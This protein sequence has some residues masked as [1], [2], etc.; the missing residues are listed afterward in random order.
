MDYKSHVPAGVLL[1]GVAAL[2]AGA[3]AVVEARG[4]GT[5]LLRFDAPV[6]APAPGQS[7]VFYDAARCVI[8]AGVLLPEA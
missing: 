3:P 1:T 7:A 4:D 5:A 8:G 6:R 2:I